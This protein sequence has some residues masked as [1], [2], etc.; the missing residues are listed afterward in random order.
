MCLFGGAFSKKKSQLYKSKKTTL[1]CHT[2]PLL[3]K[4]VILVC[5]L[6]QKL[7]FICHTPVNQL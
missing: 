1:L 7:T 2:S 6:L 3:Y 4:S 5:F